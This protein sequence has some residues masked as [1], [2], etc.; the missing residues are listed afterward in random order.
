MQTISPQ[1]RISASLTALFIVLAPA[2]SHALTPIPA[3]WSF[4]GLS[5]G[6]PIV[7]ADGSG[8]D[9]WEGESFGPN[10]AAVAI[11]RSYPWPMGGYPLELASHEKIMQLSGNVSNLFESAG[12]P[13]VDPTNVWVDLV[14]QAGQLSV[15][16]D[17][18][19]NAQFA[20]YVNT[21]GH[22]VIL[23]AAY[24]ADFSAQTVEWTELS[25]DPIDSDDF[26]RLSI[27]V[28]YRTQTEIAFQTDGENWYQVYLGG[29][30]LEDSSR[31]YA[32]ENPLI[33]GVG[34]PSG[35]PWF[36]CANSGFNASPH[37]DYLS[38]IA[39]EG[40][41]AM[42]DIVVTTVEPTFS[43]NPPSLPPFEQWL[44]DNGFDAGDANLDP[45]EDGASNWE[46][47]VAGTDPNEGSSV[48]RI[49]RTDVFSSSNCV[50]WVIGTENN[51]T[52]DFVMRRATNLNE[53]QPWT[54]VAS[55]LPR[56]PSGTNLWYDTSP[57][58]LP[59]YYQPGLLTNE[60]PAP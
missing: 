52:T 23:N 7:N 10:P 28:R 56:D 53:A 49:I 37:A 30:L 12:D 9:G 21:N 35:G 36:L 55:D 13:Q 22:L 2:L 40:A 38:A 44:V 25:H 48:F 14:M 31:G 50:W 24:N 57:P 43:T 41:G 60:T 54:V 32:D 39:L 45:D 16:P 46:E 29:E 19:T 47:Y 51:L 20:A 18:P 58:T 42:D 11:E 8:I 27:M 26:V 1:F 34:T 15:A 33:G 59:A 5:A 3:E 6:D 17:T 4:E